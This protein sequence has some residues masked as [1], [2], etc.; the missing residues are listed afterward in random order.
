MTG[1]QYDLNNIHSLLEAEMEAAMQPSNRITAVIWD[2]GGVIIHSDD[3]TPRT[4]LADRYH[5]TVGDLEQL[6]YFHTGADDA[7]E[8]QVS[9]YEQWG[10]VRQAL[11]L[12]EEQLG[13]FR[14]QFYAGETVDPDLM[15]FIRA[16]R[17]YC[18]IGVLSNAFA[19][20]RHTL[21]NRWGI[22]DSF[23]E[24][25]ISAE[26]GLAK[27]DP[28]IY[29]L[30]LSRL[31]ATPEQAIFVD[32]KPANVEAAREV[33]IHAVHYQKTNHAV[34]EVFDYQTGKRN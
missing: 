26:V 18:R 11:G 20:L 5:M 25:I 21:A 23:D 13:D 32:D 34:A 9:T 28:R 33:G 30:A 27:P 24:I 3:P 4:A 14:R 22:A 31:N 10:Q 8:G 16:L 6:V 15:V 29:W 19:D 2:L 12:S 17:A 7:R 1:T